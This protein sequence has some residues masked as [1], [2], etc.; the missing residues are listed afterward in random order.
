VTTIESGR[1]ET[2]DPEDT[3]SVRSDNLQ[4]F[5]SREGRTR[6]DCSPAHEVRGYDVSSR[7]D[8][9]ACRGW[10][11]RRARAAAAASE[12]QMKERPR[13]E[14]GRGHLLLNATDRIQRQDPASRPQS[15][16][17][18]R[19]C[20]VRTISTQWSQQAQR[21]VRIVRP[22]QPGR[23]PARQGASQAHSAGTVT[24]TSCAQP[25]HGSTTH[26]VT[27]TGGG[28]HGVQ[29]GSAQHGSQQSRR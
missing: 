3:P 19:P 17:I 11:G 23:Q 5:I 8:A 2:P 15:R 27:S 28:G 12:A 10:M 7:A 1:H 20:L 21:Y 16:T 25:V 26:K 18:T 24:Q 22:K 13:P 9:K 6:I 14:T 29:Q 4:A